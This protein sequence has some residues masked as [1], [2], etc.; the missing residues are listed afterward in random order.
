MSL[1]PAASAEPSSATVYDRLE[2]WRHL[3]RAANLA[4][5][6]GRLDTALAGYINALR[7]AGL[8]LESSLLDQRP[9]DCLAAWVV[10]HHNLADCHLRCGRNADAA[11]SLCLAHRFLAR[12]IGN[13]GVAA[14]TR[15]AAA[16]HLGETR[17]ALLHWLDRY[18]KDAAVEA[19][20]D[21]A[22]ALHAGANRHI[23][24]PLLH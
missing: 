8:V 17:I 3:T 5:A 2:T 22:P 18:G 21:D 14:G 6:D 15:Q 7:I 10:S 24:P 19:A 1:H 12:L 11:G 16:R 9:D 4:Y 13:P 20:L 23:P